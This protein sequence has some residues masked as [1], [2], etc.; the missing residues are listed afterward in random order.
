LSLKIRAIRVKKEKHLSQ[1]DKPD[2]KAEHIS[3]MIGGL[4]S[5]F[6]WK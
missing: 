6:R 5:T 4:I 1:G 2:E 3:G